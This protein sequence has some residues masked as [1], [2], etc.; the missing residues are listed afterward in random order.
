PSDDAVTGHEQH[1]DDRQ[2]NQE[3]ARRDAEAADAL[4]GRDVGDP[5]ELFE[6][7]N[8]RLA[9]RLAVPLARALVAHASDAAEALACRA[10]VWVV[11]AP[12]AGPGGGVD[13]LG[14]DCR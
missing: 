13:H 4:F 5:L 1:R 8:A 6:L 7:G 10:P 3:V 2:S 11:V 9:G 12:L 14:R